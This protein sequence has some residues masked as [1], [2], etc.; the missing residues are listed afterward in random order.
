MASLAKKNP[1]SWG[2]AG[3]QWGCV[4][5]QA[6]AS[7]VWSVGVQHS[8]P[9]LGTTVLPVTDNAAA[10]LMSAVILPYSR[11]DLADASA[12]STE[13]A[14][15]W[16]QADSAP[17]LASAI[18]LARQI[19]E[20]KWLIYSLIEIGEL[21]FEGERVQT[22]LRETLARLA[23]GDGAAAAIAKQALIGLHQAPAS[24]S[25]E[26]HPPMQLPED[27]SSR[28]PAFSQGAP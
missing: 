16:K 1:A 23:S 26:A 3:L 7:P 10:G 8:Y 5:A 25:R 17:S 20:V 13:A 12:R 22:K 27:A 14:K 24:V 28:L 21:A 2:E 18:N 11:R 6:N 4:N 19:P 15:K 9:K